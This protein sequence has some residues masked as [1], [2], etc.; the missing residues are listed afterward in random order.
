MV[1]PKVSDEV[2]G[3][4]TLAGDNS[5]LLDDSSVATDPVDN[6]P[7]E[8]PKPTLEY[9]VKIEICASKEN[10]NFRG[11]LKTIAHYFTPGIIMYNKENKHLTNFVLSHMTT[12]TQF[13]KHFS[14]TFRTAN[15]K[16]PACHIL[17]MK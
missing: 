6:N 12:L 5:S 1:D 17:V 4:E 10:P 7:K 14:T 3:S 9:F 8:I 2:N 11:L 13:Q 16:K 15:N